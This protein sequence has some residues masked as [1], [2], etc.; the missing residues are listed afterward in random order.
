MPTLAERARTILAWAD[1]KG[2]NEDPLPLPHLV[3]LFQT[4]LAEAMEEYRKRHAPDLIYYKTQGDDKPAKPEGIPIEIADFVIRVLH[5]AGR[6]GFGHLLVSAEP[7]YLFDEREGESIPSDLALL[8]VRASKLA[9]WSFARPGKPIGEIQ[10]LELAAQ[11][12]SMIAASERFAR[13]WGFDLWAAVD[14]K[15]AFNLTREWRHGGKIA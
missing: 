14:E 9:L 12:A 7:V 1:E 2:W 8:A 4:E 5:A 13:R 3:I 6:Y 10:K 15:H 11:C